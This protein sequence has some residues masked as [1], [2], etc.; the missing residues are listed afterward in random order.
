ME[1]LYETMQGGD[2][3]LVGTGGDG[4]ERDAD[5]LLGVGRGSVKREGV[6]E[7]QVV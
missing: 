4:G 2:A 3:V 1:A 5:E 7:N 6:E